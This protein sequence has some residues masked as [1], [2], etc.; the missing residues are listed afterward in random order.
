M[1]LHYEFPHNITLEEVQVIVNENPNFYIGERD[2]YVVANYLVAGKDT[3]PPVVDRK[4]AVMREL[5][6]LIFDTDGRVLSRRFHKFFNLGERGDTSTIDV[7]KHHVV[8][9]K[10]DGSMVTPLLIGTQLHWATKMGITDVAD[11]VN[12]FV[13]RSLIP[14]ARFVLNVIEQDCTPIFEWCSRSQRIVIDYPEDRLVLVAIRD[15]ATGEYVSFDRLCTDFDIPVVQ[16]MEPISDLDAFAIELRKREDIEGVVIRFDDGHMVKLKTDTYVALHRA[17]SFLENERN[18][19]ALILENKV[20]DLYPFLEDKDCAR[21][22][23][24][25]SDITSDITIFCHAVNNLLKMLH[26]ESVSRKDFA[27]GYKT[28]DSVMRS[29]IFANWVGCCTTESV[30]AYVTK[31]L[32]SNGSFKTCNTIIK[33]DW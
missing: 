26:G 30:I 7:T 5:R 8:L 28:I 20:D 24:F 27:L 13:D 4:T 10:L 32:G 23:Q 17:K 3:H 18:V 31:R 2:G 15:N 29:F 12:N 6:G 1:T 33:H 16:T 21:L 14:Y 19:V 9:E 11:Q 25:A 22:K